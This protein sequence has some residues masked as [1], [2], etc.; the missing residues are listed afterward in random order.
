[1]KS[2]G[3]KGDF[4]TALGRPKKRKRLVPIWEMLTKLALLKGKYKYR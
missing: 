4:A 1:M 2:L 3:D